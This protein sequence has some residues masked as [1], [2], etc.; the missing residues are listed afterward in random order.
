VPPSEYV[1]PNREICADAV[2]QVKSNTARI[3]KAVLIMFSF[4][5]SQRSG[6]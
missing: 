6:E 1:S 2:T 5:G 3:L 4:I